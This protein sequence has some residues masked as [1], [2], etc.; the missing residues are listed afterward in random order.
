MVERQLS[1]SEKNFRLDVSDAERFRQA[2]RTLASS[3]HD[4]HDDHDGH[5][6]GD[7]ASGAQLVF[8]TPEG[9]TQKTGAPMRDL[10]FS[11]G[12]K[13]EGECYLARLPGAGGGLAANVNRWRKQMGAD[14]LTDEQIAALPTR[15]LFGEDTPYITVDGSFSPGMGSTD[16]FSNYRML[17]LILSSNAGAVFVKMTGPK[18]LVEQNEKAFE[19]FTSSLDAKLP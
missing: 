13:G 8:D 1:D 19:Q 12:P 14:P 17:G 18:D 9:W 15:K 2:P 4:D 3:D 6:H 11:F 7:S 10:D 16:S 5:D